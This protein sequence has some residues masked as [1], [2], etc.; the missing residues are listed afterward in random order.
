MDSE[1]LTLFEC[2]RCHNTFTN[3]S[4][5]NYNLPFG[6]RYRYS[7]RIHIDGNPYCKACSEQVKQKRKLHRD[8]Q[9]KE[10]KKSTLGIPL[11]CKIHGTCD[12]LKAHKEILKDDPERLSGEFLISLIC[13]EKK[14]EK[15]KAKKKAD[16]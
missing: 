3:E 14:L 15:Y 7:R 1:E 8:E 12:I 13:G 2:E 10:I 4:Q 11:D 6:K 9:I 16:K 5:K